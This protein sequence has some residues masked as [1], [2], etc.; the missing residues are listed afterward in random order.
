MAARF[1]HENPQGVHGKP[2]AGLV[3]WAAYPASTDDLT[4]RN[5][6]VASIY[7]EQ[8]GLAEPETVTAARFL[9]P[10]STVWTPIPGGNHAQFGSY[11][12]QPGDHPAGISAA[13]QETK[14]VQATTAL[15]LKISQPPIGKMQTFHRSPVVAQ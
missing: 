6:A 13:E 9:L 2:I 7:G 10:A 11:G 1:V 14:V 8:D 12:E 15:L 5:L 3:L 4:Q